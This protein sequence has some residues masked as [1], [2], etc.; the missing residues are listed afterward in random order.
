[1][2]PLLPIK[3]AEEFAIQLLETGIKKFIIQPFH[4]ERGKFIAGTREE[5][6]KLIKEMNWNI[7][8]YKEV[9]LVLRKNLT[10]L[11]EGK[12]GFSIN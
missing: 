6:M 4:S 12:E 9:L 11:G 1:M 3:N 8:R 10:H 7:N 5:A 2:T